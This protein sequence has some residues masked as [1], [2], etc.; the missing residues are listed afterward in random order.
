MMATDEQMA[1]MSR[2]LATEFGRKFA[3]QWGVSLDSIYLSNSIFGIVICTSEDLDLL[4][5]GAEGFL[6][7]SPTDRA[8]WKSGTSE[9]G[10]ELFNEIAGRDVCVQSA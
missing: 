5:Y 3:Q 8:A 1:E 9:S 6:N 7:L 10:I 4:W 2:L